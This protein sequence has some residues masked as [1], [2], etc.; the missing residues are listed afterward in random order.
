MPV[1]ES[2]IEI[3]A[4]PADVYRAAQDIEGLAAWIEALE[5]ITIDERS[6]RP[7][8]PETVSTWVA[9]VP[10]F[11]RKLTWTERDLWD[12][13][14]LVCEFS[15][16][17]G[18]LDRYDGLWTFELLDSGGCRSALRID[19]A[20]EIPLIGPLIKGLVHKKMQA[21]SDAVLEGL[22]RRAEAS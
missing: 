14:R 20:L 6:E 21:A 2:S 12:D 4:S 5:S 16:V 1:I 8:G 18:D 15:L 10:E 17:Q 11:N 3:A 9:L 19:Y 7:A 13:E 22:K